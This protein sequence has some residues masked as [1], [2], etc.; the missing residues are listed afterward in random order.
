[1]GGKVIRECD[2][3]GRGKENK[4]VLERTLRKIKCGQHN[5]FYIQGHWED[6][7]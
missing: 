7:T 6:I 3:K 1:M 4:G 2:I 5:R